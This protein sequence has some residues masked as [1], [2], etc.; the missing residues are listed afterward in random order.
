MVLLVDSQRT[1][2]GKQCRTL[3]VGDERNA[4]IDGAAAHVVSVADLAR[5]GRLGNVDHQVEAAA[6]Q[7]VGGGWW[8]M[9]G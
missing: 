1:G 9:R 7:S 2:G 8:W 6:A 5:V 4:E 3:D